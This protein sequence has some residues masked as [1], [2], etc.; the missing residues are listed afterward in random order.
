MYY[1]IY[2]KKLFPQR[3]MSII[4]VDKA[5]CLILCKRFSKLVPIAV[6]RSLITQYIFGNVNKNYNTT[7]SFDFLV[8]I[9]IT[10]EACLT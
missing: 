6:L 3:N 4:H 9:Q 2:S 8:S 5:I 7:W 10:K 1:K